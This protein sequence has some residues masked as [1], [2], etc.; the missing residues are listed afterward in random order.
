MRGGGQLFAVNRLV[1]AHNQHVH[2]AAAGHEPPE[3]P[4]AVQIRR[5]ESR[6]DLA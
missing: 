3:R 2:I 5:H 6:D 1:V 4:R